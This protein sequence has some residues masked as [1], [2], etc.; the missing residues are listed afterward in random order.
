MTVVDLGTSGLSI[1]QTD[2]YIVGLESYRTDVQ[3]SNTNQSASTV[4][5]YTAGD[6][7]LQNSDFGFGRVDGSAVACTASQ[8]P[9]TRIEQLFPLTAGSSYMEDGFNQIWTRIGQQLAGQNTCRCTE[10][11]DN[12][13]MLSW[14][15]SVPAGRLGH[16]LVPDDLLP[17]RPRAAV[18]DE[19]C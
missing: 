16:R 14:D 10:Q 15:R 2:T 9:A 3:I 17:R 1:T 12:G 7:F 4:R 5:L 11:I 6:C 18:D 8:D 19:D 13:I